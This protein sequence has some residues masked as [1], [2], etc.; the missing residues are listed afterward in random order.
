MREEKIRIAELKGYVLRKRCRK[1]EFKVIDGIG[2]DDCEA[3]KILLL[4]FYNEIKDL[5]SFRFPKLVV[6]D[7]LRR[8][9]DDYSTIQRNLFPGKGENLITKEFFY[10]D[11]TKIA[12]A[13]EEQPC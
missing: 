3:I 2:I 5:K 10:D 9:Y 13:R 7:G 1:E 12:F 8:I 6:Y 4:N 11:V